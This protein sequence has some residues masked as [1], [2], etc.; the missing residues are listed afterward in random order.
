LILTAAAVLL[1][2]AAALA[3]LAVSGA[4]G[5][6]DDSVAGMGGRFSPSNRHTQPETAPV[7]FDP[8]VFTKAG[9]ELIAENGGSRLY[10]HQTMARI[11]LE[12]D[13]YIW[14]ST[15]HPD[16]IPENRYND[17]WLNRLHSLFHFSQ[18][19]T[20]RNSARNNRSF[21]DEGGRIVSRTALPDGVRLELYMDTVKIGLVADLKLESGELVFRIDSGSI[22][23]D[24]T[25]SLLTISPLPY[26]GT[27]YRGRIPGYIFVPDGPGALMRFAD[28]HPFIE[29][30]YTASV[31]GE[32]FAVSFNNY[33]IGTGASTVVPVFGMVHGAGERAFFAV[34]EEGKHNAQ[35]TASLSGDIDFNNTFA[36]FTLRHTYFAFTSKDGGGFNT[37]QRDRAEN[38]ISVRYIPLQGFDADYNGMARVYREYL[39]ERDLLPRN[40]LAGLPTTLHLS[41]ICADSES[42]LFRRSLVPMTTFGQAEEIVANLRERGVE[43]MSVSL[44]GWNRGGATDNR[45]SNSQIERRLGGASGLQALTEAVSRTGS[46]LYLDTSFNEFNGSG[47]YSARADTIR[48]VSG[49]VFRYS[50]WEDIYML[51]LPVVNERLIRD[52]PRL[53]GR[54]GGAGLRMDGSM[55]FSD[56]NPNRSVTREQAAALLEERFARAA[57]EGGLAVSS[58]NAFLWKYMN[59][60]AWL[61]LYNRQYT[62]FSDTVPFLPM[63]LHGSARLTSEYI[64]LAADPVEATLRS[65]EY[66]AEPHFILSHEPAWRLLDTRMPWVFTSQAAIWAAAAAE[67]YRMAA[68]TLG[69]V[70]GFAMIRHE[71]VEH[72]QVRVTYD[73]GVVIYINYT[74]LP[75]SIDGLTVGARTAIA[76]GGAG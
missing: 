21:E 15:P 46:R 22:R 69:Q 16:D 33:G 18:W 60:Y 27:T 55:L 13:G 51:A 57:G 23:E 24:G 34:L 37:Y 42:G 44:L 39:T 26:F 64:N 63:V 62:Y 53:A 58:P 56:H 49:G 75:W 20:E 14:S 6:P 31:Y 59:E 8:P 5:G 65:I 25:V 38:N 71:A 32:D 7:H 54:S 41:L 45:G 19:D 52:I 70:R 36:R 3:V 29:E 40:D 28:E 10:L 50:W 48:L 9:Y 72:G 67:S 47:G 12:H 4:A 17:E 76:K 74:D 61:P 30:M 68:E 1:V 11:L 66:S 73:N 2:C 43:D 35:I